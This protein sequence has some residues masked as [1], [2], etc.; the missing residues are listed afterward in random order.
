MT[1]PSEGHS[2]TADGV[3]GPIA[4]LPAAWTAALRPRTLTIAVTPVLVGVA[5]AF[6][7]GGTLALDV[8]LATLAG[9]LLIQAGTNLH[10]DAAD[11]AAG[12][13]RPGHRLGPPR[14]SAEGWLSLRE[15]RRGAMICFALAGAAGAYLVAHGGWPILA[16]GIASVVAARAYSAGPWRISHSSLG[17]LFVLLFFGLAAVGG[18]YYLQTGD[19]T[20]RALLAGLYVGAPA[21]AVLLVNNHRDRDE[22]RRSGRRTLALRAGVTASK[23]IYAALLTLP[24]LLLPA[25]GGGSAFTWWLPLVVAPWAA[26]LV[27][28]LWNLPVGAQLNHVLG[29]TAQLQLALGVALAGAWLV[30]PHLY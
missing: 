4:D 11:H 17:E 9:A 15:V 26:A 10:N 21:S 6:A 30:P 22:D 29:Q 3:A 23:A 8:L 27:A 5:L 28:S 1:P 2:A 24:F 12:A 16:L 20:V 14:A 7:D 13:D 18:S 25:L 19:L